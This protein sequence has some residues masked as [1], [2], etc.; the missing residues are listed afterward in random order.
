M[1][2]I[3]VIGGTGLNAIAAAVQPQGGVDTPWG[4]ASAALQRGTVG[5]HEVFFLARH[6]QP[7]R[8]APHAINYR[9]NLWLLKE[10]GVEAVLAINAVGGIH[11]VFGPGV[12]VVPDQLVDYTW[13]REST[14][15]DLDKLFHVDFSYPY[16]AAWRARL[17][18]A[19][20]PD[21][22]IH[23]FGVYACTQGPRLESAAEIDRLERDGCDLVGMTAMPEATLA[24]ELELPY[25]ALCLVVN[26]GAGRGN[27]LIEHHEIEA[28]VASG[29]RRVEALLSRAITAY[30]G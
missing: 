6:G 4:K 24:R 9:A 13:G 30:P 11:R 28:V 12:L 18:A 3:A 19:A 29:M 20:A 25:A 1:A 15:S 7:H 10:A 21:D 22:V 16:D 5:T 27:G 23:D 14:Y 17:F 26:A 8:I 2:R